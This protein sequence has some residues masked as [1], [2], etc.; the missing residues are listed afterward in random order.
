MSK[1]IKGHKYFPRSPKGLLAIREK[2]SGDKNP[3][4]RS[5]V[6]LKIGIKRKGNSGRSG[7]P[8]TEETKK[9]MSNSHLG[10]KKPW[11]GRFISKDGRKRISETH[12]GVRNKNWKG[13]ITPK[14]QAI[15]NSVEYKLWREAVFKR[16]SWTCV[17]CRQ[18]G[19][20]LEADHIKQFALFPELRFALENGR[21]LCQMCHNTTKYGRIPK[22]I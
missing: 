19:G 4:K 12:K 21:T 2:M 10:K 15:R 20:Y 5:E 3:A 18:H 6:R 1:F 9:K 8:H 16:D 22:N 11:A 17:W 7:I 14:N 13:G